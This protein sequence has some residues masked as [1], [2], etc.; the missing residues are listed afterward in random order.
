MKQKKEKEP[1]PLSYYR[2]DTIKLWKCYDS[3]QEHIKDKKDVP[4][5]LVKEFFSYLSKPAKT[6]WVIQQDFFKA[7]KKDALQFFKD[8]AYSFNITLKHA[9]LEIED[10]VPEKTKRGKTKRYETVTYNLEG[11]LDRLFSLLQDESNVAA[12]KTKESFAPFIYDAFKHYLKDIDAKV[13]T[14]YSILVIT[15]FIISK[16]GMLLSEA[17]H[18]VSPRYSFYTE[19]LYYSV[20]R[21][22]KSKKR[23]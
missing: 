12:T 9:I 4:H 15:G 10:I 16:Y 3:I 19:Y 7:L 14:D 18:E 5:T 20:R 22:A 8:E 1:L 23:K 11:F 21:I 6:E 17:Q 2:E 13:I